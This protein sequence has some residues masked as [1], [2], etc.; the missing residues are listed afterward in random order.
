PGTGDVIIKHPATAA[1]DTPVFNLSNRSYIWIEG[2]QFK[3]FIY[4]R[5][6]IY[7]SNGEGNIIINNRF[8]NLGNEEITTWNGNQ[9]I[10]LFNSSRNVVSNNYFGNI[11][12]DGINVNSQNSENNLVC[13]NTFIGFK[14]KL[15]GWGGQNLY[16]RA[17]DL[18]DMS[19]GNN[20][21]AFNYGKNLYHLVWLDR[22][23]SKNVVLRNYGDTGSGTVFNE[24]RCAYNVVQE[25]ISVN[26]KVGFMSAYYETT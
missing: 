3:E 25:N 21:V 17:I 24:S 14:G 7:I 16:S 9:V 8:E 26:M 12:G 10:G 5:A 11:Y 13:N 15:R 4:G 19:N 6:S 18:Q 22:D 2:F 20:V 1:D 23:G